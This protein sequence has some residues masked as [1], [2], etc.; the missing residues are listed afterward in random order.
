MCLSVHVYICL[1][2]CVYASVYVCLCVCM[3]VY[4]SMYLCTCVCVCVCEFVC[5]Y[6]RTS[7]YAHVHMCVSVSLCHSFPSLPLCLL[8][9]GPPDF[10]RPDSYVRKNCE[11]PQHS[12]PA[13]GLSCGYALILAYPDLSQEDP[14]TGLTHI[15]PS[16]PPSCRSSPAFLV[17]LNS[18]CSSSKM[19]DSV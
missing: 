12:H 5:A 13:L 17:P 4:M 10:S 19:S 3:L 9:Q 18:K 1:Y 11:Q 15:A 8:S 2:I 6:A 16:T 14:T 7:T